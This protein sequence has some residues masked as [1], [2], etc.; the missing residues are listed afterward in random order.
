MH[1][2]A[3]IRKKYELLVTFS[4]AVPEA[5][6]DAYSLEPGFFTPYEDALAT[7]LRLP[8]HPF[9]RDLLIFLGIAHY[10]LGPNG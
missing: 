1:D 7:G 10:Q 2:L 3:R 4:I 8:L 6:I 5:L 9:T